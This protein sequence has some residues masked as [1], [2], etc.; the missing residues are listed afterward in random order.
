V[1]VAGLGITVT[2]VMPR[3]TPF[4][5]VGRQGM[6]AYAALSGRS[7]NDFLRDLEPVTT[8]E[9]AGSALLDLVRGDPATTAAG[10][11]LT[12]AGLQP[13]S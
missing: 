5:E 9:G 13:V 1:E 12:G 8:P 4:G 3:M 6:R 2:A 10:Y 7:E 11:V